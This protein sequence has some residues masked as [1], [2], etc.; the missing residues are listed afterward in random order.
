MDYQIKVYIGFTLAADEIIKHIGP[1]LDEFDLIAYFQKNYPFARNKIALMILKD[2]S[3]M[4]YV[5]DKTL[6]KLCYRE[7]SVKVNELLEEEMELLNELSEKITGSEKEIL[8]H[9]DV[10]YVGKHTEKHDNKIWAKHSSIIPRNI[11][12]EM[13]NIEPWDYEEFSRGLS[14]CTIHSH[15]AKKYSLFKDYLSFL[16][17]KDPN[18]YEIS[19]KKLVKKDYTIVPK[20][21]IQKGRYIYPHPIGLAKVFQYERDQLLGKELPFPKEED[22]VIEKCLKTS[23]EF[24]YS[25]FMPTEKENKMFEYICKDLTGNEVKPSLM[26]HL[27]Y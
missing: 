22:S 3:T 1:D 13:N 20:T 27:G 6:S 25:Q 19:T 18:V 14:Q 10:T 26:I 2:G 11:G 16:P 21:F 7:D 5:K 15:F 12:Y 17:R 23:L 4:F 24:D 8:V 9:V